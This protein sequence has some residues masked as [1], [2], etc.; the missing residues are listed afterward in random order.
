MKRRLLSRIT[1]A[2]AGTVLLSFAM[3]GCDSSDPI[4]DTTPDTIVVVANQGNFG[5]GNGSITQY[6]PASGAV[7]TILSQPNSIIQSLSVRDGLLYVAMNTGDRIDV[8]D[9]GRG[10]IGQI[11]DVMSPRYIDWIDSDRLLVSNL[12]ENKVSVVDL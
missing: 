8:V 5:D 12:F 11:V 4:D 2:S 7:V 1:V 10:L 3:A 6:D 9:A